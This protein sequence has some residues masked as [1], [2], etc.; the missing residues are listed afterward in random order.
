MRFSV[1]GTLE[2]RSGDHRLVRLGAAKQRTLLAVLLLNVNRPVPADRLVEALWPQRP[3]R[4]AAVA[5]RTYVSALR[6]RVAARPR[7]ARP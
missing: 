5:L 4:T 6:H 1:L 3:P 2:V 7:R